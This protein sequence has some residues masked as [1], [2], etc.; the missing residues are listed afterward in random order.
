MALDGAGGG[1]EVG[2]CCLLDSP[3]ALAGVPVPLAGQGALQ[4]HLWHL[5]VL[6]NITDVHEVGQ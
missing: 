6:V 2:Q 3:V 4:N 5:M 1:H